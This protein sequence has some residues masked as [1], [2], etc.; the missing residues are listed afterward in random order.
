MKKGR[1]YVSFKAVKQSSSQAVKQS[2]SQAV[3]QSSSQAVKQKLK[4]FTL[5][6]LLVSL[7]VLGLIAGLT[8]P[9]IITSV[10]QAKKKAV[11]KEDFQALTSIISAGV[12]NGD[13]ENITTWDVVNQNGAGSITNYFT[14]KLNAVRQ[15][16]TTDYTSIGCTT[17][18]GGT[19]GGDDQNKHNGRWVMPNG[20]K[21]KFV[22]ATTYNPQ[23]SV[24][25]AILVDAN[26]TS[27]SYIGPTVNF[28][29]LSCNLSQAIITEEGKRINPGQC[30]PYIQSG[31]PY[32]SGFNTLMG[33]N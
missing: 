20:S 17:N 4:G 15:C 7:A 1:V 23:N 2:S 12:L 9:S 26:Q 25:F 22:W 10:Q 14:Q 8:V 33:L 19:W 5:S 16:L 27:F 6:E 32:V 18:G 31:D 29:T 24:G 3:K 11:F 30:I 28:N 13:F 21:I